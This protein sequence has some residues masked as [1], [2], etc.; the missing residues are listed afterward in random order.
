MFILSEMQMKRF[1]SKYKEKS[2][3]EC[4]EWI[5]SNPNQ[6]GYGIF[7]YENTQ[8]MA[9]RMS[10][11]V[12][13]NRILE[14]GEVVCHHCDNPICVNPKHLFVG[15]QTDNIKDM[16]QKGRQRSHKGEL[17]NKSILNE[18]KVKEIK[19]RRRDGVTYKSLAKEFSVSEGCI[20]H[21][22]NG[23]HWGWVK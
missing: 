15:T 5:G 23:R 2:L 17:N 16:V 20:N 22:I 11:M 14:A 13:H 19:S 4:W 9:H 7:Y 1:H 18:K 6:D 8:D 12:T 10:W 3:D 21:I